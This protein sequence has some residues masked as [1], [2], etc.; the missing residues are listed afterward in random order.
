MKCGMEGGGCFFLLFCRLFCTNSTHSTNSSSS[1]W[2]GSRDRQLRNAPRPTSWRPTNFKKK[3]LLKIKNCA[4][5]TRSVSF[6]RSVR[7]VFIGM[8]SIFL[9][10]DVAGRTNWICRY[11][12][13][14]YDPFDSF[15][16]GRAW[17]AGLDVCDTSIGWFAVV[18]VTACHARSGSTLIFWNTSKGSQANKQRIKES[19]RKSS[20]GEMVRYHVLFCCCCCCCCCIFKLPLDSIEPPEITVSLIGS[21]SADQSEVAFHLCRDPR[22]SSFWRWSIAHVIDP[23]FFLTWLRKTRQ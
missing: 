8:N 19:P 15:E 17:L 1:T 13:F 11:Q 22:S 5:P 23:I 4:G 20:P 7:L 14:V 12:I 21:R 10:P 9:G 18:K 6:I 3:K 2:W 16:I